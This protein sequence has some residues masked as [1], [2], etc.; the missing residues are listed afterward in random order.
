LKTIVM[1]RNDRDDKWRQAT[2][3][4]VMIPA[5]NE[6]ASIGEVIRRLPRS[7]D[8]YRVEVLVI[9]DGSTDRTAAVAKESGADSVASVGARRGLARAFAIGMNMALEHGADI[10]VNID[11]DGQYDPEQL[12]QLVE[13]IL[14]GRADLVLGSRFAGWI[15]EMPLGKRV[16]NRIAT[17]MTS[18]LAGVNISDAQTGFRAFSREAAL[19]LNVLGSYTYVQETLIQA[20]QKELRIVEIPVNF[21]K[22]AYGES[23]LVSSLF[24]YAGR[25]GLTMLRTYRDYRPLATFLVIGGALFM[26]G[27]IIGLRV[28]IH[29][30]QTGQVTPFIPSA[31][32]TAVLVILGFQVIFLGLLADMLGGTRHLVEEALYL[33]RRQNLVR[34]RGVGESEHHQQ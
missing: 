34:E 11:A 8:G 23:R 28:L 24:S 33:L 6:E 20:A 26:V 15:E 18:H 4:I 19:K 12:P 21:R 13:P 16:G 25:A 3:I 10:V 17:I 29:F 7:F 32:L 5:H 30:I 27:V 22:R 14:A 2:R 1:A 31:I 9:D